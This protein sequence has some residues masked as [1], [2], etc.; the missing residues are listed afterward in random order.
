MSRSKQSDIP[1]EIHCP[2]CD[3]RAV[4][5]R[6]VARKQ[7]LCPNCIQPLPRKGRT[8]DGRVKQ[9][10]KAGDFLRNIPA[11]R[12]ACAD[13]K[14]GGPVALRLI[15]TQTHIKSSDDLEMVWNHALFCQ[16]GL[17]YRDPGDQVREWERKNGNLFLKVHAGEALNPDT[18]QW[19][20]LGLPWGPKVRLVQIYLDTQ[21]VKTQ[22]PIIETDSSLTS[23]ITEKLKLHSKGRNNIL[24]KDALARL[25]ASTF[26]IGSLIEKGARTKPALPIVEDFDVWFAKDERQRVLFPSFVQYTQRY[27]EDLVQHAVPLLEGAVAALSHNAMA[28]DIYRWLAH[29][30]HRINPSCPVLL[31]WNVVHEQFGGPARLDNFRREFSQALSEVLAVY[32][33][34]QG[35]VYIDGNQTAGRFKNGRGL[36]LCHAEPPVKKHQ[37]QVLIG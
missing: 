20:K 28:L 15:H 24:I 9:L 17:P 13:L 11:A 32:P 16:I 21:A 6:E 8:K 2:K 26:R 22:S 1:V 30:L 3:Y 18:E 4:V 37:V 5:R 35:S 33:Q 7:T 14:P 27:Y 12:H 29:R 25:A 36:W 34:A 31:F 10:L 19:V 23:F